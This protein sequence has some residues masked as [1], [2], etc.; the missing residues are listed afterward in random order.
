MKTNREEL[1]NVLNM[2]KPGLAG[3]EIVEQSTSF[4]FQDK[5]VF[6]YNDEIAVS[7]PINVELRGAVKAKELHALLSKSTEKEI[8]L[9]TTDTEL[10]LKG[11]RSKAGIALEVEL[12]DALKEALA[13]TNKEHKWHYLPKKFLEALRFCLFSVSRDFTNPSLTCLH[14]KLDWIESCDNFRLTRY[15]LEQNEETFEGPWLL[16][17]FAAEHLSK[18]KPIEF[19]LTKGW[20]FF[21]NADKVI[22]SCRIPEKNEFPD[23]N[24]HIKEKGEKVEIPKGVEEMLEKA[25]IFTDEDSYDIHVLVE[26]KNNW[27]VVKGKNAVGWFEEKI[28]ARYKGKPIQFEV[29]PKFLQEILKHLN[30]AEVS[31]RLLKFKGKGYVHCCTIA[32]PSAKAEEE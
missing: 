25:G 24:P 17:A 27:L 6:T 9:E 5:Q 30:E 13:Q 16:P 26:L 12:K 31:D 10:R 20:A 4:I 18:Y 2:V 14:V 23:L 19:A 11:K 28:R 21:R 32:A 29:N 8:E 7:H 3:K 1:L 22:F 15:S